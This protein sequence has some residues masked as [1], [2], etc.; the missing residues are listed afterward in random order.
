M[1]SLEGGVGGRNWVLVRWLVIAVANV[2]IG[3]SISRGG[4]VESE[5][6]RWGRDVGDA[7]AVG[8]GRGVNG[9]RWVGVGAVR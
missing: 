8:S 2:E 3:W 1:G 4:N 6:E 5:I 9:R 7:H